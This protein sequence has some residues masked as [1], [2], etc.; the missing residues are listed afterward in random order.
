[1]GCPTK[2]A[3]L[4]IVLIFASFVF[5]SLPALAT[6]YL[7]GAVTLDGAAY[8]GT[9]YVSLYCSKGDSWWGGLGRGLCR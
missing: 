7:K 2:F 1:M 4:F 8:T 3:K 9:T 6:V 5:V